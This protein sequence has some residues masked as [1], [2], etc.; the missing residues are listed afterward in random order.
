MAEAGFPGVQA[1]SWFGFVVSSKTLQPI[2]SRLQQAMA[3]AQKDPD[4]QEKL[5]KQ[6]ASAGEPGPDAFGKLIKAHVLK[7]TPSSQGAATVSMY[8]TRKRKITSTTGPRTNAR[9]PQLRYLQTADCEEFSGT[10]GFSVDVI[11]TF[12][13]VGSGKVHHREKFHTDYIA[14]D[15]VR[16]GAPPKPAPEP[17][18]K[19]RKKRN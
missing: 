19:P 12:R 6:G 4:Y 9:A 2:I 3:V 18:P 10:P 14:A 5:A 8:S 1:E 13:P 17:K 15:T 11:R 7:S 16:C